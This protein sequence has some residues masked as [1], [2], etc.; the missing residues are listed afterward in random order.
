MIAHDVDLNPLYLLSD[1]LGQCYWL[2]I[3]HMNMNIWRWQWKWWEL[4]LL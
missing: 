3:F 2:L 1:W 4:C